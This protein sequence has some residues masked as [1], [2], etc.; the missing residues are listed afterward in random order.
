MQHKVHVIGANSGW[1]AQ[2]H[3]C[4]DAPEKIFLRKVLT[5][6][7]DEGVQIA[8][9]DMLYSELHAK[10]HHPP[11]RDLLP[12]I[13]SMN[14]RLAK[15]VAQ[16]LGNQYFPLILGGDHAI[17]VGTWNGV[18]QKVPSL[19]LL[20]VDAHMDSHTPA[21]TPSGAWHGMPLAA[22]LG[23][24]PPEMAALLQ[25]KPVF[26]PE[27]VA[28]IG[29][30]SFEEGEAELLRKLQV[31]IYYMQEVRE[32]GLDAIFAE[33][34]EYILKSAKHFGVSWDL[35]V[36]DPTEAPGV[37][38]LEAGGLFWPEVLSA[39]PHLR[40]ARLQA[41]ELVEYNP[42]RDRETKTLKLAYRLL[43]EVLR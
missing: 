11:L 40:D 15:V 23:H 7:R 38:S 41:F 12:L 35:D 33:A 2:V 6:L 20:W 22:L 34:K 27:Q 8:E 28:L 5:T 43:R 4:E 13:H 14:L 37:G 39:L 26:R 42:E 21:T 9:I 29:V 24:G 16:A 17:A 36:F 31:K 30:R 3:A 10:E 1:G 19:G 25:A 32:R 18:H